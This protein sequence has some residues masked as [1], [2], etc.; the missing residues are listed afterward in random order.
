MNIT[1]E[2]PAKLNLLLAVEPRIVNGKHPLCSVFTTL[3]LHDTL[4]F[5]VDAP[6]LDPQDPPPLDAKHSGVP[7]VALPVPAEVSMELLYAKG[8]VPLALAPHDNIVMRAVHAFVECFGRSVPVSPSTQMHITLKK[9][10]PYQAGLGG[11]SSDAAATLR[12]LAGL[13]GVALSDPT[14][15]DCARSLGA[16]VAFFLMQGC[17]LMQGFGDVRTKNLPVPLLHLV[18]VKPA[19]GLCTQ[20][21]YQAFDELSSP[22]PPHEPLVEA[23]ERGAASAEL[24]THMANNLEPASIKMLNEIANIREEM[25]RCEGLLHA[26]MAGSGSAVFG[27]CESAASAEAAA[28]HFREKAYWACATTTCADDA[29]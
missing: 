25:L 11:G 7:H 5:S 2:A 28:A 12:V 16:D 20:G 9:R 22:V 18:L 17:A 4:V 24:A 23:L 10:I 21:V 14:L 26:M 13:A 1:V 8:M 3:A 6:T 19:A 15:L 27:V 29:A